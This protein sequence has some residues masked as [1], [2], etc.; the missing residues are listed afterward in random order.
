MVGGKRLSHI[1]TWN[2][3]ITSPFKRYLNQVKPPIFCIMCPYHFFPCSKSPQC[4]PTIAV[5]IDVGLVAT[6]HIIGIIQ[7]FILWGWDFSMEQFILESE[8][9]WSMQ[10]LESHIWVYDYISQ[11]ELRPHFLS[12]PTSAPP[13]LR[14]KN[15]IIRPWLHRGL[16]RWRRRGP[17]V[18]GPCAKTHGFSLVADVAVGG[19]PVGI[20][21]ESMR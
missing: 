7:G 16:D 10:W 4:I 3:R 5:F 17:A 13:E 18:A 9:W 8:S 2:I 19:D 11:P 15:G 6:F 21:G 12:F 20:L 1:V 14:P